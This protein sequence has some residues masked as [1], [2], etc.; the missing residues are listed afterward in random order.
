MQAAQAPP[1]CRASV[2]PGPPTRGGEGRGPGRGVGVG[3]RAEGPHGIKDAA[4]P[5]HIAIVIYRRLY[6]LGV[7]FVFCSAAWPG[8]ALTM[9]A[10]SPYRGVATHLR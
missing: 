8:L 9:N 10:K 5:R 6:T 2:R 4:R 7:P 3:G 1:G